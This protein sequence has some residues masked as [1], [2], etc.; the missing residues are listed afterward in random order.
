MVILYLAHFIRKIFGKLLHF[1]RLV[2]FVTVS[3]VRVS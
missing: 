2:L 3:L 1:T